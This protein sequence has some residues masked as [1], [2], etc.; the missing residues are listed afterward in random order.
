MKRH[1]FKMKLKPDCEKE[2]KKRHDEIWPGNEAYR[3][4]GNHQ[5]S[6][7]HVDLY[8]AIPT[9]HRFYTFIHDRVYRL[10]IAWQNVAYNQPP[11]TSFY[12][13]NN[14]KEQPSPSWKIMND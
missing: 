1:A 5:L 2:Y 10:G 9:R 7:A 8:Y 6:V 4:Q 14:M 11:Y 12:I 3:G 13:G